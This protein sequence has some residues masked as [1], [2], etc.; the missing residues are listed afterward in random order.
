MKKIITWIIWFSWL[1][2]KIPTT[3]QALAMGLTHEKNIFGDAINMTGCRS[4][5]NDKYGRRFGC[6]ELFEENTFV[7]KFT[8][9]LISIATKRQSE[10]ERGLHAYTVPPLYVVYEQVLTCCRYDSDMNMS[11][12]LF[13]EFADIE[14]RFVKECGA[15]EY[16]LSNHEMFSG[17]DKDAEVT[18]P[19]PE[20]EG[21]F[22]EYTP[23]VRVGFHDRFVTCC[24]THQ[25][26][27]EFIKAERHNLTKPDIWVYGIKRRNTEMIELGKLFG[28]K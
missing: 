5:W 24:F 15:N 3:R 19:D 25:A 18:V 23:A 22:I 7:I 8:N 20:N 28:D 27:V 4:F 12:T 9:D 26:A 2:R 17:F 21:E 6:L 13:N 10:I 16:E 14:V 1:F 11:T